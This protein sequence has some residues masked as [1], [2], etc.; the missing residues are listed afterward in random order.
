MSDEKHAGVMPWIQLALF[1]LAQ[2]GILVYGVRG[3]VD[4]Q[5]GLAESVTRLSD[6]V[7][8]VA[9][10]VNRLALSNEGMSEHVRSLD[11]RVDRIES[12]EK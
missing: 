2:I 10:E 5:S 9:I 4:A 1:L 3:V 12:R 7:E 8:H 11:R 6:K